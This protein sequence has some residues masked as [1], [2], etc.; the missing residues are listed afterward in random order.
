VQF[1]VDQE[2][3][4]HR[5]PAEHPVHRRR[6]RR[7]GLDPAECLVECLALGPVAPHHDRNSRARCSALH[8]PRWAARRCPVPRPLVHRVDSVH[9]RLL[10]RCLPLMHRHRLPRI[11]HLRLA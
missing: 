6:V 4:V 3:L 9:R 11:M 10:S 1:P 2:R 7:L 8:R 5:D